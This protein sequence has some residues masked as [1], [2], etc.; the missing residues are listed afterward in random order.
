MIGNAVPPP[1]IAGFI[2]QWLLTFDAPGFSFEIGFAIRRKLLI[3][4]MK[5]RRA[6]GKERL[7]RLEE[8]ATLRE[9]EKE[10]ARL[11]EV[12]ATL[13]GVEKE[14]ARLVKV[15]AARAEGLRLREQRSRVIFAGYD[16]DM[17]I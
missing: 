4:E 15:E 6:S 2:R 3:E 16:S 13:R 1:F 11:T 7:A 12:E 14:A 17:E 10:A 5:S 8:E 9:A